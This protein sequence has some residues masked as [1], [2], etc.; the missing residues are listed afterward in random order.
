MPDGGPS[1]NKRPGASS[2]PSEP[3]K[4]AKLKPPKKI[5]WAKLTADL[6]GDTPTDVADDLN[7]DINHDRMLL[8]MNK[9]R[10]ERNLSSTEIGDPE[11]EDLDKVKLSA[12]HDLIMEPEVLRVIYQRYSD[13][14]KSKLAIDTTQPPLHDIK[15]IFD[16]VA[17]KAEQLGFSNVL[18]HLGS[19][20]LR[21]ATMC[22]GTESP[23]LALKMFGD[24]TL[25]SATSLL[26]SHD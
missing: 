22:S 6:L 26:I 19:R 13:N 24:S 25:I 9:P 20:K 18:S 3:R 14:L 7:H 4:P 10:P 8:V 23:L 2:R 16:D 15:E 11:V 21:V 5:P 1:S 17:R 12:K